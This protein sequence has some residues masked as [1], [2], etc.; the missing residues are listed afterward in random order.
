MGCSLL[1]SISTYPSSAVS[2]NAF[3]STAKAHH[4]AKYRPNTPLCGKQSVSPPFYQPSCSSF[5]HFPFSRR[6]PFTCKFY[7]LFTIEQERSQVLH[8]QWAR[9]P[10]QYRNVVY[11]C[12]PVSIYY[13]YIYMRRGC[14]VCFYA[15]ERSSANGQNDLMPTTLS[16]SQLAPAAAPHVKV[17]S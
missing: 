15:L 5:I 16:P 13:R 12:R 8:T 2:F 14:C 17:F 4:I 7:A 10:R 11:G 6:V 1:A 9:T 3:L